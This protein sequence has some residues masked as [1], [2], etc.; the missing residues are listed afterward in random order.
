MDKPL[1][2]KYILIFFVTVLASVAIT[3]LLVNIFEK[4]QEAVLYPSVFKPVGEF[5]ID[6]KLWGE[7]F[8]FEYDT[9]RKT[10]TNE[11]PTFYGG[12]D[13][14]QKLEKYPNLVTLY[15]GYS[16]SKDYR[17]ERGHYWSI[18]DVQATKRVNDK[19]ANTCITCKS[20]QVIID[21]QRLGPENFYKAKFKDIGAHYT[22]SIA[23]LDCH[24]PKT[25]ELRVVRPAFIEAMQRRGID[26]TKASRQEMRS[27]V[28]GQCHVEY[29]FK[30]EGE[31][32]TFP[33]D[34][35]LNIDSIEAHYDG[36][37]FSDWNHVISGAPMIKMQHP[38]FE[39][40]STGIHSR[41]GVSCADCHMP[42]EKTGS[43][44]VTNHWTRSPLKN[45]NNACQ[46]CHKWNEAELT[47]RV[48]TIQDRTFE[49][50]VKAETAIIAAINAI[51]KA[52]DSG[53]TDDHLIK[54]RELHRRAQLR[55]DFV[56]AENSMG[57]HSPQET[58]RTLANAID[59][60]RQS[61]FEAERLTKQLSF[62]SSPD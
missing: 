35:G 8:P 45:M 37:N 40:W 5:E 11:G 46:T 48:R 30:G 20:P 32:L 15:A 2:K 6:P 60:A 49:T 52:K 19:T 34:K 1:S 21:I 25:M 13:N 28:C 24:N 9:Y 7:N 56:A 55:W 16:F 62:V 58:M 51:K 38:E 54:A 29:Y 59:Y 53:A 39:T 26:I 18:T 42:Y 27:Y 10:E 36:Y 57:F 22:Q 61:Q 33:W 50:M 23:C 43:V 44:K 14:Y 47:V 12:S 4:K 17:E 41:S 31:Y 3:L